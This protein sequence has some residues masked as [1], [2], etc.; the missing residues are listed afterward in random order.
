MSTCTY[1]P[2]SSGEP[3][4]VPLAFSCAWRG[5][6]AEHAARLRPDLDSSIVFDALQLGSRC[7]R[8]S[9]K[10]PADSPRRTLG[11]GATTP[12]HAIYVAVDGDD[13]NSGASAAA[14]K[15]TVAAGLAAT[16]ALPAPKALMLGP[17]TFYLAAALEL[18][19][20]DSGLTIQ[21]R[22]SVLSG[23]KLLPHNLSWTPAGKAWAARLPASFV[24]P[25]NGLS[26]RELRVLTRNGE[27]GGVWARA[28]RARHPN[29]PPE[30]TFY[31]RGWLSSNAKGQNSQPNPSETYWLPP[32]GCP[33]RSQRNCT[34]KEPCYYGYFENMNAT[35]N[36]P[37]NIGNPTSSPEFAAT[38]S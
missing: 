30:T 34:T 13:S 5:L 20:V 28:H 9:P 33:G 11:P 23:A 2:Y 18:T 7:N 24:W 17:G 22:Q 19:P 21:G 12:G 38:D 31:P 14:P 27:G 26:G 29:G 4:G 16:R 8:T 15:L 1:D 36:P 35:A 6:A 10:P 3:H 32:T 25:S 37:V